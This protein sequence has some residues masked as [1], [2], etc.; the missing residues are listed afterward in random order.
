MTSSKND[1]Q[2]RSQTN[3]STQNDGKNL[4]GHTYKPHRHSR[5]PTGATRGPFSHSS[6]FPYSLG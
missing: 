5:Y 1:L 2:I 4:T 3:K 6:P